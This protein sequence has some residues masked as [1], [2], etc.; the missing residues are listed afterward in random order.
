MLRK[1][2]SDR[3]QKA[4]D[5]SRSMP[6]CSGLRAHIE[7]SRISGFIVCETFKIAPRIHRSGQSAKN[8]DTAMGMLQTWQIQ[9]P[10][11]LQMP[12]DLNH[13]DPSCCILHMAYNQL[14]VLITRPILFAAVK[15][16]VA[17]K[18]IFGDD[19]A[20]EPLSGRHILAGLAAADR[21]LRLARHVLG[22]NRRMLQAGLHFLFNG[23][24]ILLLKR[25]MNSSAMTEADTSAEH[26]TLL[27]AA[28]ERSQASVQFAIHVFEEEAKTGTH[29]PR[30][31][32]EILSDLRALTDRYLASLDQTGP[33]LQSRFDHTH[34]HA[35]GL[36]KSKSGN[37]SHVPRQ[38]IGEDNDAYVEIM[39][40][41][42]NPSPKLQNSL[43]I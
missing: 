2:I 5:A 11:N 42:Q 33:Y 35:Q 32:C 31:C 18:I 14:I 36:D 43:L 37:S 41:L 1:L 26:S 27:T 4:A 3:L 20:D 12:D 6:S 40:W 29:Y 30:D 16:A 38:P 39:S 23:A 15:R 17:H 21:N 10:S 28:D 8:I 13:P 34:H 9:L 25:M 22:L 24:L 19:P 7:L